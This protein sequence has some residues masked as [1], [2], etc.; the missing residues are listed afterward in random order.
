MTSNAG[1]RKV[2]DFGAG[3]GFKNENTQKNNSGII[4]KE[5]EK[6]FSPEF[7]NRVD[8]IVMFNSLT[9]ENIGHIVDNEIKISMLR[10]KEIG[11][12]INITQSLKD[13][14][15]EQ[16]YDEKYGARPLK[17]AIQ[18]H[19]EDRITDAIINEEILIG[20]R[21]SMRYDKDKK[22][23]KLIKLKDKNITLIE[24]EESEDIPETTE[25]TKIN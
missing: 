1:S 16:G 12:E 23:I 17:R 22:E 19:V 3:I 14:L 6:I 15:F 9:K 10:M 5:L 21:I 24:G 2:K 8:D 7:L 13:Y 18:K 25:T 20:D 4:N 11:Y